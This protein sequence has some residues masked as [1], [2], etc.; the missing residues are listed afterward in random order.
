MRGLIRKISECVKLTRFSLFFSKVNFPGGGG[1]GG[2]KYR[3]G[4]KLQ[5]NKANGRKQN[6]HRKKIPC[7]HDLKGLVKI[8]FNMPW[9]VGKCREKLLSL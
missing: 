1:G 6:K 5:E 3:Y 2:E 9:E 8:F 4:N 7:W